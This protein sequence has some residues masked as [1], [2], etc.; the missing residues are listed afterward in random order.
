[1]MQP[2]K[3]NWNWVSIEGIIFL[4]LVTLLLVYAKRTI[5]GNGTKINSDQI[6]NMTVNV[7]AKDLISWLGNERRTEQF[8]SAGFKNSN[9]YVEL[10]DG[11]SLL[12]S[13]T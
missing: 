9:E 2:R 6:K 10:R 1:M 13:S 4:F 3:K 8:L 12:L 11:G 7:R 5:S